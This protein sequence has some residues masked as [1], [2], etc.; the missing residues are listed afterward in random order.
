MLYLVTGFFAL[1]VAAAL[2][3]NMNSIGQRAVI[4]GIIVDIAALIFF[5]WQTTIANGLYLMGRTYLFVIILLAIAAAAFVA[6]QL[7][8]EW[9]EWVLGGGLVIAALIVGVLGSWRSDVAYADSIKVT[10]EPSATYA[11]RAPFEVA[12]TL[13]PNAMRSNGDLD[14]ES[15]TYLPREGRYTSLV[16]TRSWLGGYTEVVDQKVT[17]DG[18]TSTD[19]CEFA[20]GTASLDGMFDR[21]LT[22]EILRSRFGVGIDAHNAYGFCDKDQPVIVVAL[23]QKSGFWPVIDVPA[24]VAVYRPGQPIQFIDSGFE[25]GIPGPLYPITLA[26][27][28]RDSS[29]ATGGFFDWMFDRVG[30]SS[31]KDDKG[32]PNAGNN[33]EFTLAEASGN[34]EAFVTPLTMRG[35]GTAIVAVSS[36]D[37][38]RAASGTL[39]TLTIHK[40]PEPRIANSTIAQSMKAQFQEVPWAT[41][42]FGIFEVVPTS[43]EEWTASLGMNQNIVYHVAVKP[44]GSMC[45]SSAHGTP[46]RCVSADGSTGST[47]A[48]SGEATSTADPASLGS[49][50]DQQLAD[51]LNKVSAEV[52]KRLAK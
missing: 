11:P 52:N 35:H 43:T 31:T 50:T 7:R 49:M 18:K 33:G 14:A 37:A 1:A 34:T 6:G 26:E 48:G 44:D 40:L 12:K 45:L 8:D 9:P 19:N 47:P 17:A 16:K 15:T 30:Y 39:A 36:V 10:D 20:T 3:L 25:G 42:G 28:Q 21:N 2:Y 41:P 46:I 22:R 27:Q 23:T 32:D 24:G 51:L 4:V 29:N 5:L 13:A 38:G